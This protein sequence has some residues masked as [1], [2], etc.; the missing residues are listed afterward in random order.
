LVPLR[1]PRG[2]SHA[3]GVYIGAMAAGLQ[4]P[5]EFL[6]QTFELLRRE[7]VDIVFG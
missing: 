4:E 3:R 2:S 6:M 5:P 7:E 1:R